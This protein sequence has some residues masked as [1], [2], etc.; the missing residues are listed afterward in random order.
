M[1]EQNAEIIK[2]RHHDVSDTVITVRYGVS[3]IKRRLAAKQAYLIFR[4]V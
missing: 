2:L 1:C 4:V 3:W